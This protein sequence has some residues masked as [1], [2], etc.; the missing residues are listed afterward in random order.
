MWGGGAHIFLFNALI[1]LLQGYHSTIR[2]G[3]LN[4]IVGWLSLAVAIAVF[5]S[6]KVKERRYR[7]SAVIITLLEREHPDEFVEIR[8]EQ[9]EA[10]SKFRLFQRPI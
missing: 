7:E 4:Y 6:H 10:E 8:K 9:V 2:L 3:I 1:Q 5:A